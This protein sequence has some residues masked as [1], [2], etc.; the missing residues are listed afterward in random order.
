MAR[1]P[2]CSSASADD[3]PR[4]DREAIRARLATEMVTIYPGSSRRLVCEL[5]VPPIAAGDRAN[6]KWQNVGEAWRRRRAGGR[7]PSS[8]RLWSPI[9]RLQLPPRVA[10]A[11][12]ALDWTGLAEMPFFPLFQNI[13][14][15][16]W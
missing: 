9:W 2:Q 13:F 3:A 11:A 4:A 8:P 16:A 7:K 12:V 5:V 1:R 6:T 10:A 15:L 14:P